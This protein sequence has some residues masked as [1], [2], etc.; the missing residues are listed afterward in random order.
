[1]PPIIDK[2]F[3]MEFD[4]SRAKGAL[5]HV[6]EHLDNLKVSVKAGAMDMT[7]ELAVGVAGDLVGHGGYAAR[8]R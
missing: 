7:R 8:G 1:M 5:S 2:L 4:P 3:D 6:K